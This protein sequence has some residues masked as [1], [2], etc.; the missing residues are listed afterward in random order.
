MGCGREETEQQTHRQVRHEEH[1]KHGYNTGI[2]GGWG[3]GQRA[4]HMTIY[5]YEEVVVGCRVG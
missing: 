3:V 5:I 4:K 1:M 2:G